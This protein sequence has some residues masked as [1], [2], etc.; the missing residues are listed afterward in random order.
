MFDTKPYEDKIN[1]AIEHFN[2]E[3]KKVRTGRAHPGQLDGVK[4][5]VYGSL[6]PINQVANVTAPE[7]QLLLVS[8]FDPS[9]I[10]QI[11]TSIRNYPELDLNPSDDGRVIR[12]PIPSLTEERRHLLV[13]QVGEKVEDSKIAIRNIRQEA[14]KDLRRRKDAKEISGDDEK[15]LEKAIDGLVVESNQKIEEIFRSKER[16]ILKI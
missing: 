2:Q 1:L 11:I 4:V 13:K 16:E 6:M 8:P 3:I 7:A 15:R 9:N 10:S 5:E 12:I 14:L